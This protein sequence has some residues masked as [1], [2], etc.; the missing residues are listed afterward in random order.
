MNEYFSHVSLS[1]CIDM[2]T[3]IA[4]NKNVPI[5]WIFFFSSDICSNDNHIAISAEHFILSFTYIIFSVPFIHNKIQPQ[6]LKKPVLYDQDSIS[7]FCLYIE[8]VYWYLSGIISARK[9]IVNIKLS[10]HD[11]N[12]YYYHYNYYYFVV[13]K[14]Q[15]CVVNIKRANTLILKNWKGQIL[16]I[17]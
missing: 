4:F 16:V 10:S 11:Y 6:L 12:C 7:L 9:V 1:Y 15:I 14:T 13:L 3:K 17:F 2:W 5:I 8:I